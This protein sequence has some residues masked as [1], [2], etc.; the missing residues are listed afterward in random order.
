[1][2]A[3]EVVPGTTFAVGE[4]R[5]LFSTNA[6]GARYGVAADDEGFVMIRLGGSGSAGELIVVENF[7]EE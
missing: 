3:A 7:F 4:Q 5:A 2:V 1:M 6:Y